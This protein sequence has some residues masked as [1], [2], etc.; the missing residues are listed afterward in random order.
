MK[1]LFIA[2][3]IIA[4]VFAF[5]ILA[6]A[7]EVKIATKPYT[8]TTQVEAIGKGEKTTKWVTIKSVQYPLYQTERGS[9]FYIT[10]N[11]A[12]EY[13]RRYVKISD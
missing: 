13:V 1:R 12:G 3:F 7:Q 2:L 9:H 10:T 5:V 8:Y 6:H 4:Q 11:K